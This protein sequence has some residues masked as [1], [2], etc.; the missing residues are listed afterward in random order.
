[1][2]ED[3]RTKQT[4]P[5]LTDSS[6]SGAA[7]L[8]P[9]QRPEPSR[10]QQAAQGPS[11]TPG[12]TARPGKTPLGQADVRRAVAS[13]SNNL[14]S[15][16]WQE[17]LLLG[18]LLDHGSA[19][20]RFMRNQETSYYVRILTARGRKTLWGR[21]FERALRE[22]KTQPQKGD[23]IGVQQVRRIPVN[24][25]Q[26]D[27]SAGG[28]QP[29]SRVYNVWAVEKPQFFAQRAAMARQMRDNR[30]DVKRAMREQPAL[31]G[32]YL[33]LAAAEKIAERRIK[34]PQERQRFVAL[35]RESMASWAEKGEPLPAVRLREPVVRD[36]TA[37]NA[38]TGVTGTSK[39]KTQE[40]PAQSARSPARNDGPERS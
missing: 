7:P 19:P 15:H 21:D 33:S 5:T 9:T 11:T 22:S 13:A 32:T 10:N 40:S 18:R 34:D 26:S 1:M 24:T 38:T 31:R 35:I 17:R 6:S 39:E 4:P 23:M 2:N 25:P 14:A 27:A 3:D 16:G 29:R 8:A 37:R 36:G 28:D 30:L 12:R 20:Y